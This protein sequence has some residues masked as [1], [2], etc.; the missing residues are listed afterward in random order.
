MCK[1]YDYGGCGGQ[2]EPPILYSSKFSEPPPS[3]KIPEN[4]TACSHVN[5]IIGIGTDIL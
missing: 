3:L 2:S 5:Y 4:A 1:Y